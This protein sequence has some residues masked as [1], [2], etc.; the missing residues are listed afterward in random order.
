MSTNEKRLTLSFPD[1][2]AEPLREIEIQDAPPSY[3]AFT[4][5]EGHRARR[6]VREE[7]LEV[8]NLNDPYAAFERIRG[9]ARQVLPQPDLESHNVAVQKSGEDGRSPEYILALAVRLPK[10]LTQEEADAVYDAIS[11]SNAAKIYEEIASSTVIQEIAKPSRSSTENEWDI[12]IVVRSLIDEE[13]GKFMYKRFLESNEQKS[14][15]N[16]FD[17]ALA[18]SWAV[19][20]DA[21]EMLETIL[22]DVDH[23]AWSIVS[24]NLLN[25]RAQMGLSGEQ[26]SLTGSATHMMSIG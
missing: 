17:A 9:K 22:H 20:H 16:L 21:T 2:S 26:R 8:T 25:A 23:V 12:N 11:N 13:A 15:F 24:K 10:D 6:V 5:P 14:G 3:G 19:R 1:S 4:G 7:S 18:H